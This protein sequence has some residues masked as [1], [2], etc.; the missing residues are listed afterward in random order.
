MK[1]GFNRN[2]SKTEVCHKKS[3]KS[4]LAATPPESRGAQG[5]S[6]ASHEKHK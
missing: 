1:N 3:T 4:R 2:I 5:G 6:H